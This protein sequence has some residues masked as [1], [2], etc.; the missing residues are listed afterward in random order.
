MKK[1]LLVLLVCLF[2]TSGWAA[3]SVTPKQFGGSSTTGDIQI[4]ATRTVILDASVYFSG[5]TVGDS[6]KLYN[7]ASQVG[8][9]STGRVLSFFAP[10]ANGRLPLTNLDGFVC[11][12][13]LYMD[14]TATGAGIIGMDIIYQ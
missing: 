13:G 14:V 12:N 3:F 4:K 2:A 8:T 11:D 7:V 5:V 10:T 9:A 1:F 6:L